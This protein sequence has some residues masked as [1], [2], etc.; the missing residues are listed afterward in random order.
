M[1]TDEL[2][3][4]NEDK[5]GPTVSVFCVRRLHLNRVMH[6]KHGQMM[7]TGQQGDSQPPVHHS[8][9][10]MWRDRTSLVGSESLTQ[11][12]M[13]KRATCCLKLKSTS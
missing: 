3:D 5:L 8:L 2:L 1:E 9:D 13:V 7:F 4:F 6:L 11:S 12:A 10:N